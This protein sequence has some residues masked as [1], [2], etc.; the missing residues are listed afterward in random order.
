MPVAL[1]MLEC[2]LGSCDLT[3]R[4]SCEHNVRHSAMNYVNINRPIGKTNEEEA[5]MYVA[6]WT[7]ARKM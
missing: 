3:L 2:T 1:G 7:Q 6:G 4:S 5:N